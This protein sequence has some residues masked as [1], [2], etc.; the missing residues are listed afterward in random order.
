MEIKIK[1]DSPAIQERFDRGGIIEIA[2][3]LNDIFGYGIGPE[4]AG[5][6]SETPVIERNS[7]KGGDVYDANGNVAGSWEVVRA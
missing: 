6:S 2:E 7:W 5:R 4:D 3:L 1:L